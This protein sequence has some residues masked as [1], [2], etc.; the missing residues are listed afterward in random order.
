LIDP[1]GLTIQKEI[2]VN[3]I[4]VDDLDIVLKKNDIIQKGKRFFAKLI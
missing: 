3:K 4:V 1:Q 2:K